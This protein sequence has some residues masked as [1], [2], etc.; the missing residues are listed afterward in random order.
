M[1]QDAGYLRAKVVFKGIIECLTG[2]HIGGVEL[3]VNIGEMNKFVIRNPYND[4]PYIPGSSLKGKIRSLIEYAY[5]D[6]NLLEK[7]SQ[8]PVATVVDLKETKKLF[9]TAINNNVGQP[10]GQPSKVLFRDAY[11]PKTDLTPR[12]FSNGLKYTERK[13]ENTLNRLRAAANPRQ[14]ERVPAGTRF[15]CSMVLNVDEENLADIAE[16]LEMLQVGYKLLDMDGLG[17]MVSRGYGQVNIAW[18]NVYIWEVKNQTTH[19]VV[20][21]APAGS[22]EPVAN[23]FEAVTSKIQGLAL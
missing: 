14:I 9:G 23:I 17:G 3:G 6:K 5:A 18:N 22:E 15:I 19:W 8:G 1:T 21:D 13:A 7:A 11:L 4:Q 20:Q 12:Q 10:I 16:E 2:L